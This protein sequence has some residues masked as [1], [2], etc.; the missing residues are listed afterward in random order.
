[1]NRGNG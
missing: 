1:R